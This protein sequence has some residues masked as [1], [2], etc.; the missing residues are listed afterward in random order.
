MAAEVRPIQTADYF[1]GRAARADFAV[2]DRLMRRRGGEAL[3]P[4]MSFQKA[5]RF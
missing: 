1:A 3:G 2:F 5:I 4:T